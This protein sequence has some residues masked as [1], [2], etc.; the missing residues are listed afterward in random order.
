MIKIL[1]TVADTP[2]SLPRMSRR[3]TRALSE[4]TRAKLCDRGII[5]TYP[6]SSAEA[7]AQMA[8]A[9]AGAEREPLH[10][11]LFRGEEGQAPN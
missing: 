1:L 2:A 4:E 10:V 11:L 7:L 9:T 5:Y 3:S 8:R 6:I